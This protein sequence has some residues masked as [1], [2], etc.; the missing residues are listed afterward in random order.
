MQQYTLRVAGLADGTADDA[1]REFFTRFGEV[2]ECVVA[3][4][5][6]T[7]SYK[8]QDDYAEALRM[9]GCEFDVGVTLKVEAVEKTT[10]DVPQADGAGAGSAE[11]AAGEVSNGANRDG[12]SDTGNTEES[13]KQKRFRDDYKVAVRH[14]PDDATEQQLRNMFQ[15]AGTILDFFLEPRRR[16]AFVGFDSREAVEAALKMTGTELNGTIIN[17]ELKRTVSRES[18]L[19]MKVVVKNLPPDVTENSIRNF[20]AAVGEPVDIFIHERKMFAFVGFAD[21]S[22]CAAA[23]QMDGT[24]MD[25][26][27]VQIERRQRQRCFKCNK[28]GH[29][30]TQCRGEPTCRT[31]GRPGHMARDCRMQPGSYDRNRGGNMGAMGRMGHA[32]PGGYYM[33]PMGGDRRGD[34]GRRPPYN[35]R[36][37]GGEYDRRRPR[38]RS[39]SPSYERRH[40]RRSRSR[41]R[42]RTRSRSPKRFTRERERGR[43]RSRSPS[44]RRYPREGERPRRA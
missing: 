6:A 16:Y 43:D 10:E 3:G 11:D 39:R 35:D 18:Q 7:V 15:S 13:N 38:S 4:T 40:R 42:S 12:L 37:V 17:V 33:G 1:V 19:E 21:E 25:G 14:L 28:E 2:T 29:V 41:S 24:E 9:D 34:V 5:E 32:P 20:F 27:R 36:R 30:A 31:C 26:H 22:A 23:I 44:R 8:N